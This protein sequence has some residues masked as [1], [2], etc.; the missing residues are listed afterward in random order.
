MSGFETVLSVAKDIISKYDLC[1]ICLGRFFSNELRLT[2]NV[3]LG[4][5]IRKET[6]F[7][8]KQCYIC[9]NL[10]SNLNPYVALMLESS[11]KYDY[12]TILVGII[13]KP[14][15]IER[16]DHLRSKYK[17]TGTDGIKTSIIKEITKQFIKKS[18]KKADFLD[19]ELTFT[20]NFKEQSCNIRSKSIYIFGRYVKTQRGIPQ[21]QKPCV[22]CL[23]NG[24]RMCDYHGITDFNSVEGN[25]SK[26]LFSKIGGTTTK[27]TWIGGEDKESLVL[28]K[29][30]PFFVKIN[31][32]L[33][34]RIYFPKVI[35]RGPLI[36]KCC[37]IIPSLPHTFPKFTS[38]IVIKIHTA[39]EITSKSLKKLKILS[40]SPV[41]LIEKSGKHN[42]K[43]I[44]SLKY[45]KISEHSFVLSVESEGGLPVKRFVES[46]TVING[47]SNLLNIPC[48]CESFDFQDVNLDNNK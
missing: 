43:K 46:D 36:I 37:K 31:N 48:S 24:C 8:H 14:S 47:V 33:Q 28:G 2:S 38:N 41:H 21:K 15:I 7:H 3:L 45:K 13:I 25:I 11:E 20:L 6:R 34:R 1:D 44:F 5:K 32:P 18:Q 23:G 26:F 22:N 19:P 39:D 12:S 16:D 42:T 35:T 29:G 40:S 17:L 10:T 9:K 27:F 4:K 30:R